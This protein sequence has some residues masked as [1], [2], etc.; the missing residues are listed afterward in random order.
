[1][2]EHWR[3]DLVKSGEVPS[4]PAKKL[5]KVLEI[6]EI[7]DKK[8]PTKSNSSF[9]RKSSNSK[10][11]VYRVQEYNHEWNNCPKSSRN[12]KKEEVESVEG[13]S[14]G[15]RSEVSLCAI[16]EASLCTMSEELEVESGITSKK[17]VMYFYNH[18]WLNHQ[19]MQ[20]V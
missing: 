1:M 11:S 16:S 15:S 7:F 12:T 9:A 4:C 17:T 2:P 18:E 13:D 19:K 6:F 14:L 20:I 8:F 3:K 10:R 5:M